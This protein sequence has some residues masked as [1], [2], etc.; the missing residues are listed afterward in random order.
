M[1]ECNQGHL[2]VWMWMWHIDTLAILMLRS[3]VLAFLHALKTG[4]AK[5]SGNAMMDYFRS[6]NNES[7]HLQ[8]LPSL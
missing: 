3:R 5:L 1:M 2:I 7:L 8:C 6:T 4:P